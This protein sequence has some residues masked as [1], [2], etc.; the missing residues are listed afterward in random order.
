[1]KLFQPDGRVLDAPN[2]DDGLVLEPGAVVEDLGATV[3]SAPFV[4]VDFP[5]F[6]DGRGFS[7]ARLLRGRLGYRGPIYA[8]GPLIPDQAAFL[9][10][11]GFDG[12]WLEPSTRLDPWRTASDRFAVHAQPAPGEARPPAS[13]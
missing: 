7:T 13:R 2:P 10:R 12:V 11:S 8:R 4:V 5:S 1:M 9:W 3:K 6:K